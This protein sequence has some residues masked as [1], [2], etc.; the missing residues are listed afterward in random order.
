MVNKL[1]EFNFL[2]TGMYNALTRDVEHELLKCLQK[3]KIIFN[4]Y[5]PLAGGLLSPH[6]ENL[7]TQVEERSRFDPN[8]TQ[9]Q[10]YRN[11][12]WNQIYFDAI[13][14]VHNVAKEN[15]LSPTDIALRWIVYHSAL[16]AAKGDSK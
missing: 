1:I 6:Y 3:Y 16:N 2:Q 4:A 9:G 10:Q 7:Q 13:N 12:Y 14:K 15:G 5:N 8:T 11:R